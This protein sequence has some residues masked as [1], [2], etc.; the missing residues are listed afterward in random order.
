MYMSTTVSYNFEIRTQTV[1]PNKKV[2]QKLIWIWGIWRVDRS[3]SGPEHSVLNAAHA[4]VILF[5]KAPLWFNGSVVAVGV[6]D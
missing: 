3:T 2:P 1:T 6:I 5:S 4:I